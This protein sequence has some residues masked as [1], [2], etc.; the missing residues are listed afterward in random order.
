M[1]PL[2]ETRWG[3]SRSG[4]TARSAFFLCSLNSTN[5]EGGLALEDVPDDLEQEFEVEGA[6]HRPASS[7]DAG[8]EDPQQVQGLDHVEL[9]VEI[10]LPEN[11]QDEGVEQLLVGEETGGGPLHGLRVVA[12]GS[13]LHL[14]EKAEEDLLVA[15]EVAPADVL[16]VD[17]DAFD[18]GDPVADEGEEGPSPLLHALLPLVGPH[19]LGQLGL[20]LAVVLLRPQH[21]VEGVLPVEHQ[22]EGR[23]AVGR[24]Y[25]CFCE[26]VLGAPPLLDLG[27][28][29]A[30]DD[31][32]DLV[33]ELGQP[34]VG[35]G[36]EELGE[37]PLALVVVVFEGLEGQL[38]EV[39]QEDVVG[40]AH[41]LL[42]RQEV[43]GLP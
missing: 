16:G 8:E 14:G 32:E 1:T 24:L 6:W 11:N 34:E 23:L 38:K 18:E 42:S 28:V 35:E 12:E 21:L 33:P 31:R 20:G 43:V 39:D 10:G 30:G 29:A 13:E 3:R 5:G 40:K 4:R 25:F 7:A 9:V 37:L 41:L 36:A 27:V 15:G 19:Q 22:P 17:R 26:G 2:S